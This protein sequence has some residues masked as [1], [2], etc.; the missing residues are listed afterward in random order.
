MVKQTSI[1]A[2]AQVAVP[3]KEKDL[4]IEMEEVQSNE[5]ASDKTE[6]EKVE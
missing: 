2:P 6:E 1:N 4:E 5:D 3:E